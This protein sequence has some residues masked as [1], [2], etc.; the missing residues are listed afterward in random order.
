MSIPGFFHPHRISGIPQG[1]DAARRWKDKAGYKGKLPKHA[2][3]VDGG[4]MSNFPI[5]LFHVKG[6]PISPTLGVKLGTDRTAPHPIKKPTQ[7]LGAIFN[8]A[9]HCADYD[10]ILQHPDYKHLVAYIDTGK[11][12]WLNFFMKGRDKID[13]FARGVN[14]AIR[15][16]KSFD[17]EA[18]KKV[19][20]SLK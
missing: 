8:S 11:H 14:E 13:L 7:M 15:F 19:R 17:W 4:I 1:A 5:N 2:Y 3:F 18:Y 12:N 20:S 6:V 9:R 16:L 10:F